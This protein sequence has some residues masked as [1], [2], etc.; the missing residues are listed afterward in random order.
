MNI[1][2]LFIRRPVATTLLTIGLALVG[3]LAYFR[4]PVAALPQVDFPTIQVNAIM[5]GASPE[6][7]ATSVATV[8]ERHLG[9][10]ADVTEITSQS[11]LGLTRIV[12]Q[13]GL[14]RNIDGATRDVQAAIS[15]AS[16][17]LPTTMRTNPTY[18]KANPADAPIMLLALTSDTLSLGSLFDAAST[19]LSQKL[20]QVE[21]IG[22][23]N[24]SG[25]S[26]PAVR[27]D[28]NPTSL[29]HYS[30]GLEDVR[31]A[32]SAANANSPKG[33]IEH[34]DL[35][36]QIYT[37]KPSRYAEHY[38]SLIIALRNNAPV[39]LSDVATVTDSVED[40]R[41]RGLFNGKPAVL[42]IIFRSPGANIIKTV[43]AV[44]A[45]LPQ[46][47]A[48]IPADIDLS[49]ALDRTITIRASMND[50][51]YALVISI[52][53]VILVVYL[54][55]R[56]WRAT[57]IPAVAVPVSLIVTFGAMYLLGYSLN[58]FSLMALIIAT[59]FVVDDAIVVLENTVRHV[60]AGMPRIKA[61]LLGAQEVG[62]TVLSMSIS[63]IAVFIP[64]L[65]LGGL[66][67][68]IFREFAVVLSVTI[69]V[70]LVISLTTTPMMCSRLL[71]RNRER[72]QKSRLF[73]AT[74][75]IYERSLRAILHHPWLV[76]LT[77]ALTIALNVY[78]FIIIPKGLFP[79][80]DTGALI[81]GVQAD[82]STSFLNLRNKIADFDKI[83]RA[84]P[85]VKDVV[86]FTGGLTNS[87]FM[88]VTLKPL[89]DRNVSAEQIMNRLR[90]QFS[91]IKGAAISLYPV[92][93]FRVGGRQGNA[94]YQFTLRSDDLDSLRQ[95]AP[96]VTEALRAEP[97]LT[98]INSDFQ[99]GG[100][101]VHLNVNRDSL[102]RLG[103]S[104]SQV[105]S[106]LYDAFGQRAVSTIYDR[107]N[108]YSIVM[109]LAPR[110]LEQPTSLA[111]IYI[112]NE[113]GIVSA[114]QQTGAVAGTFSTGNQEQNAQAIANN[115]TRN[116]Q[117][118]QLAVT[119]R[120]QASSGSPVST[121]ARNMI[122]LSAFASHGFGTTPL[123]VNHQGL[124]A[125]STISFNLKEGASLSDAVIVIKRVMAELKVP[126]S[127]H[128]SFEGTA[129]T[130]QEAS[131]SM[132]WL[133]LAALVT[134]YIV[135]G[136]LY[137]SYIHPLT[138]LSTLPSA[139]IGAVLALMLAGMEFSL[140]ALIGV[141]LLIGIVKKNAIMMI[142]FAIEAERKRG[143]SP[144]EAIVEACLLRFRPIMMTTFAAILGAVPLAIGFGEG[145]EMRQ[146]LG[147]AIVGGLVLSQLLTL[148][149]T[150]A[151]YLLLDRLQLRLRGRTAE[152]QRAPA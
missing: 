113:G 134:I 28:I 139:G 70:S 54:F 83:I 42:L 100:L 61:A 151:I 75:R 30:I 142:D 13:F 53:L 17:D 102:A 27:V 129:R 32:L 6:V 1:S 16:A 94:Q 150:P 73:I 114:T 72:P 35:R 57:F 3:M 127:I 109:G 82:Q 122:P 11:T 86:V 68:R 2:A 147:V 25:S 88:I 120:T 59:G 149:T 23:V 77:L 108:Q 55:L 38:R 97:I 51:Q 65:L 106:V 126:S 48:S 40:V 111:S 121:I 8:L 15:A 44:K 84:D 10:I 128:G 89:S 7:M 138:I 69:L 136:M 117:L 103:L 63:L 19:V 62:F 81:G 46:L 85:A 112:S 145:A 110:Y 119:G 95:W 18:Q 125:A 144:E 124:F 91:I 148:Y 141:F 87:A 34:G 123:S 36:W 12:M 131:S 140:V 9:Q 66:P 45:L 152:T 135:L 90:P 5:A 92:Q 118:N 132:A 96:K 43:D 64:L 41:N 133:I 107:L 76:V 33:M 24:I 31:A 104:M 98:D 26:L 60:E 29:F 14:S 80:Q 49:I 67:G 99:E 116:Q 50:V 146:P 56:D 137:E 105:N 78:L 39:R 74:M 130:F 21:G 47:Q 143:L 20:S 4:L 37:D 71:G 101:Q 79:L 93:D 58:N 115:P 52:V 22:Q